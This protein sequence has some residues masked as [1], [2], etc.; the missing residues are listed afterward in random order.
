MHNSEKVLLSIRNIDKN[1]YSNREKKGEDYEKLVEKFREIDA[2]ATTD[3]VAKKVNSLRSVYRKELA[4]VNKSIRSGAGEDE[5]YEP[6]LWYFDLLHCLND[7]EIRRQS[8]NTMDE[9]EESTN[10]DE[11]SK[12]VEEDVHETVAD[13]GPNEAS[14]TTP[15]SEASTP[16]SNNTSHKSTRK[17]KGVPADDGTTDIMKLVGNKLESLQAEDAFQVFGKHVANRRLKFTK[18]QSLR[19]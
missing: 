14:A 10:L 5:I 19:N 6:S 12:Q 13:S 16:Y 2:T 18:T 8:R 1:E 4:K 11:L 17:R 3:T 9:G 7:Q 15:V